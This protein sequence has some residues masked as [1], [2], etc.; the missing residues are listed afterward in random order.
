ML[1]EEHGGHGQGS[2]RLPQR[3]AALRRRNAT[4]SDTQLI[5]RSSQNSARI[6]TKWREMPG[7][8]APYRVRSAVSVVAAVSRPVGRP[9]DSCM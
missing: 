2:S 9:R 4:A 5:E 6:I 1:D 3:A 8:L 7:A